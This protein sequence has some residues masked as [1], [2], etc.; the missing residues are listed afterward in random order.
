MSEQKRF[1]FKKTEIE[2]LPIPSSDRA[3]YYDE[4][5]DG[6]ALVVYPSGSKT[7]HVIKKL[8]RSNRV[9]KPKLGKFGEI[10]VETARKMALTLLS[11]I[12]QGSDPEETY[13]LRKGEL[14]LGQLFELYIQ[15]YA[16]QRCTT[17]KD[18]QANFSRYFGEWCDR[19][20]SD[21]KNADVQRHVNDLG[22]RHGHPTANR[23]F[24]TLRAIYAWGKKYGHI[25]VEN[26]CT[27]VATFKLR[28]RERFIRP[29]EF[30]KFVAALKSE[31]NINFRDYV[32]LSLFTGA[33]QGNVLA[34]RWDEIDFKLG[35]WH[36]PITK[37]KESQTLPLTSLALEVLKDRW[38]RC[39]PADEWVFPSNGI[40]GHLVEPKNGWRSFLKKTGLKDLRM[41]DLRR[42]LGS[43][44]AMNNQSLQIIGK[45]LGHK[46]PTATQIYSRLAT[47]P[48]KLAMEAAQASMVTSADILPE[49]MAKKRQLKR[50]K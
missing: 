25:K 7:F 4:T 26:P 8:R 1:N 15:E 24:D 16:R 28:S 10:G 40:T 3:T 43:Y 35:L 11:E 42:T 45:V 18:M 20:V 2:A 41:H 27:G 50:V 33:R 9:I 36:I 5:V 12:A 32:Y 17:W 29:D 6:L 23:A 14:T 37:N 21:I 49:A 22:E 38:D 47:D 34:M 44:M 30:E 13:R 39:N 46:S 48:L 19:K 31:T